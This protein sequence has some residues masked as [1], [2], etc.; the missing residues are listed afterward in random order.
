MFYKND[1]EIAIGF[2]FDKQTWYDFYYGICRKND[3]PT[4][5]DALR[6]SVQAKLKDT[7]AFRQDNNWPWYK[8][9]R[10]DNNINWAS[11]FASTKGDLFLSA[12]KEKLEILTQKLKLDL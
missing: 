11:D 3:T 1:W 4:I 2:G 12:L 5:S 10:N 9:F 7:N 8:Y 6:E